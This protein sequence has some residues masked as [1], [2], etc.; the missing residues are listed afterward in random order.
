MKVSELIEQLQ[1]Y[2]ANFTVII[3]KD[4]E[5]NDYSPLAGSETA[6]YVPESNWS[7]SIRYDDESYDNSVILSPVN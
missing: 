3:Q 4:G 2:P 6:L 1:K 5:G 7:G